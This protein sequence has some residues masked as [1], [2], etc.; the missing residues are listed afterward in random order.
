MATWPKIPLSLLHL[1]GHTGSK[2][3][4]TQVLFQTLGRIKSLIL[5]QKTTSFL[6]KT[7]NTTIPQDVSLQEFR[8]TYIHFT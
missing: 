6:K 1:M 7:H 4:T 3:I 8:P 5:K 2:K